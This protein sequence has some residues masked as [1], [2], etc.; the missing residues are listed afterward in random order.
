MAEGVWY[1]NRAVGVEA[2]LTADGVGN[3]NGPVFGIVPFAAVLAVAEH[4]FQYLEN[5]WTGIKRDWCTKKAER[6]L[7]YW[8]RAPLARVGVIDA[9]SAH[10]EGE[11]IAGF[12]AQGAAVGT[13]TQERHRSYRVELLVDIVLSECVERQAVVE[14]E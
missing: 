9:A 10:V 3:R 12:P 4:V 14:T 5:Q 13:A 7:Y 1:A 8:Q 6:G 2:R 11:I